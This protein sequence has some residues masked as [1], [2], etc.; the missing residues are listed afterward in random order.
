MGAFIAPRST[1]A[2]VLPPVSSGR[3]WQSM[4]ANFNMHEVTE[5]PGLRRY[6][7]GGNPKSLLGEG[8][9]FQLEKS[10]LVRTDCGSPPDKP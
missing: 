3:D 10:V 7:T 5:H 4:S 8:I 2:V 9:D 1:A 6:A